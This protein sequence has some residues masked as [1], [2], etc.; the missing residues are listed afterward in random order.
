MITTRDSHLI[1]TAITANYEYIDSLRSFL[2]QAAYATYMLSKICPSVSL[3][4]HSC[5]V[6][7]QPNL[8]SSKRR[9]AVARELQCSH[10]ED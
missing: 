9:R 8:S 3:S 1:Y 10:A 4:P 6:L 5:I 2:P 7:K